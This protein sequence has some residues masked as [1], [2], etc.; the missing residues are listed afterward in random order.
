MKLIERFTQVATD[1]VVWSVTFDDPSTWTRPWT[2]AMNLTPV[3][4]AESP[5]EYACHE[6]NYAMRNLLGSARAAERAAGK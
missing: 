5:F 3:P 2:F 1:T 4:V 6:G